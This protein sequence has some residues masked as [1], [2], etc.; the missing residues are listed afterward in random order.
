[1]LSWWLHRPPWGFWV[2]SKILAYTLFFALRAKEKVCALG[3]W[4]P[5]K[6]SDS[7]MEEGT[8]NSILS[9]LDDTTHPPWAFSGEQDDGLYLF[10]AIHN[11][12]KACA[13]LEDGGQQGVHY[14]ASS[15]T[16]DLFFSFQFRLEMINSLDYDWEPCT[17]LLYGCILQHQVMNLIESGTAAAVRQSKKVLRLGLRFFFFAPREDQV[18][19]TFLLCHSE[20]S[21]KFRHTPWQKSKE[22]LWGLCLRSLLF[23]AIECARG[24][25]LFFLL[26]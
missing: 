11:K 20:N 21:W 6:S 24:L 14:K 17:I 23:T 25:F 15:R 16:L 19:V 8:S 22:G 18:S 2:G 3:F 26:F 12:E 9:Y 1:M 4:S 5:P 13:L 7:S 10:F